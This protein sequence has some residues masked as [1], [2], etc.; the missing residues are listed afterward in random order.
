MVDCALKRYCCCC[1][2]QRSVL[3]SGRRRFMITSM[4]FFQCEEK[5]EVSYCIPS[6]KRHCFAVLYSQK[7][8]KRCVD[9][10]KKMAMWRM[11][12]EAA[13]RPRRETTLG[14]NCSCEERME[15]T[16]SLPRILVKSAP[17]ATQWEVARR[18]VL[19]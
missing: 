5:H 18:L 3:Q 1:C 6:E 11:T 19:L 13:G 10:N 17:R 2:C 9:I 8:R 4:T 14:V 16:K 7:N 12:R 15:R